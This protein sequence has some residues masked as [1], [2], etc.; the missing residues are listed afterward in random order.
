M[1]PSPDSIHPSPELWAEYLYD[2]AAP[3]C[4]AR[5]EAHLRDCPDCQRQLAQWQETRAALDAWQ[6]PSPRSARP[7]ATAREAVRWAAAALLVLGLGWGGGRL[8]APAP[9]DLGALRAAVAEELRPALGREFQARLDT[10]LQAVEQRHAEGV[11]ALAAAW[12]AARSEDQQA[13]LALHQR[14]ERQRLSDFATLRRDL[15]TVAIVARD[16]I[17]LTRQQLSQLA[18]YTP[19]T[20]TGGGEDHR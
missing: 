13:T 12:A 8:A 5:L 11:Q 20:A 15:E 7:R 2:E 9:P 16:A 17:G 6:L 10:A 3:A 18:V 14:A 19:A 1:N 4:R